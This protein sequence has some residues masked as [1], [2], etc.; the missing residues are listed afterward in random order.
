MGHKGISV[1]G[2]EIGSI[3]PSYI[4]L[5]STVSVSRELSKGDNLKIAHVRIVVQVNDFVIHV[6]DFATQS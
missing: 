4:K 5:L 1:L 3:V 2:P 6:N